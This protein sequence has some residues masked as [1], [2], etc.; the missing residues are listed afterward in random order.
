MF[1]NTIARRFSTPPSTG[2]AD[3]TT[4]SSC[5]AYSDLALAA[6]SLRWFHL[7]GACLLCLC[8]V[9]WLHCCLHQPPTCLNLQAPTMIAG[10]DRLKLAARWRLGRQPRSLNQPLQQTSTRTS[11][12][13]HLR[14]AGAYAM[15]PGPA[16]PPLLPSRRQETSSAASPPRLEVRMAPGSLHASTIDKSQPFPYCSTGR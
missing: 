9:H 15:P 11:C 14:G 4:P 8:H 1:F 12:L 6:L 7:P 2:Y 3:H 5:R 16:V 10:S 13:P